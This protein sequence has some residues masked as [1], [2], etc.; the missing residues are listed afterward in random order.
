MSNQEALSNIERGYRM[1][2][3]PLCPDAVYDV[4]L[5]CWAA[6]A[7][8]RPTFEFLHNFFEDFF[9]ST[10]GQYEDNW[11]VLEHNFGLFYTGFVGLCLVHFPWL[12]LWCVCAV[13]F[14]PTPQFSHCFWRKLWWALTKFSLVKHT[15]SAILTTSL[16]KDSSGLT[17][18]WSSLILIWH[19]LLHMTDSLV[20]KDVSSFFYLQHFL[21]QT[22]A[23][24]NDPKR[25]WSE[26][27]VKPMLLQQVA[28]SCATPPY[29][30]PTKSMII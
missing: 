21:I 1:A 13:L 12:F 2:R 27:G 28:S 9:V 11:M 5:K 24:F 18:S 6:E 30:I 23:N 26:N 10:E 25:E 29:L 3:P 8:D 15:F 7:D 19:L 20:E 22:D 14:S 16:W 4:M 17:A